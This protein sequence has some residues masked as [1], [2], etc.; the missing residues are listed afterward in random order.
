MN[1]ETTVLQK[2]PLPAASFPETDDS[3]TVLVQTR[4]RPDDAKWLS[5]EAN[6]SGLSVAG[7]LRRIVVGARS[8]SR[9]ALD[10]EALRARIDDRVSI[11]EE[12]VGHLEG[13]A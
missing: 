13:R 3:S 1:R 4:L 2:R 12:R 6:R 11:L 7:M 5:D 9:A 10:F 8:D